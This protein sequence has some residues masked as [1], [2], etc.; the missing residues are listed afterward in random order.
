MLLNVRV[1]SDATP[2]HTYVRF[3][4]PLRID[5]TQD[6][7]HLRGNETVSS[8]QLHRY[9]LILTTAIENHLA[10]SMA[11][12]NTREVRVTYTVLS[13]HG[14]GVLLNQYVDH[15]RNRRLVHARHVQRQP[16]VR[17][18]TEH[19]GMLE[20]FGDTVTHAQARTGGNSAKASACASHSIWTAP[21]VAPRLHAMCSGSS[22]SP[23][24]MR[25]AIGSLRITS[26][27]SSSGHPG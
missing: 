10:V 11:W 21:A 2:R 7:K 13:S 1:R 14:M 19:H 20:Q 18:N 22:F 24:G 8:S 17:L 23:L 4:Q 12:A 15:V 3:E 6:I 5:R 9:S 16:Q 25:S 27:R 26:E